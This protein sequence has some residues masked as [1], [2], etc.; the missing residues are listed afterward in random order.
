MNLHRTEPLE[1]LAKERDEWE[2]N[3]VALFL[4]KQAER[5]QAFFTLG[6]IPVKRVYS[7]LDVA[8]TPLAD[9]GLPGR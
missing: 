9:I 8:D 4:N 6:D 7:A 1:D 3:E 5:K 2:R